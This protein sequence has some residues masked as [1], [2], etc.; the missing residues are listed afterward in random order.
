M[1]IVIALMVAAPGFRFILHS[2]LQ[3]YCE[4]AKH[5]ALVAAVQFYKILCVLMGHKNN[6]VS[7]LEVDTFALTDVCT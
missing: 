1:K 6:S 4:A 3:I 2:P 5:L 7:D